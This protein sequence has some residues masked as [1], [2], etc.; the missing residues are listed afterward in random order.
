MPLNPGRPLIMG[1]LN[2]TPDSFSDGG[3]HSTAETAIEHARKMISN[4]ADIIDIGGEST[5]PGA[6][7]VSAED[8]A[9]RVL[10]VISD[11]AKE[12]TV[13]SI[14]TMKAS[15]AAQ[16]LRAGAHIINDVSACSADPDMTRVAA[17]SG[18]GI[19]LM[20]MQGEPRTMQAD[21]SY[22]DVV[23]EICSYLSKRASELIDAGAD[24][25]SIMLDPGIGFGKTAEHNL[26]LIAK[27]DRLSALD[28]PV[29]IG[30]SRKRFIGQITG[31]DVNERL[32]GTLAGLVWCILKG[33]H[34]L[35]VHDVPQT[36][37]AVKIIAALKEVRNS[38]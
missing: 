24:H 28:F 29:L 16:A 34:V 15:V 33:V 1:I 9:K 12:N 2:V 7:P 21:P 30:L 37:D 38:G 14:D 22:E 17:E 36:L 4:G 3:A 11:L 8:E 25:D 10:P 23:P 35:R 27:L 13:I 5:R 6:E 31:R 26:E 19:V 20:H 32:A 18:A